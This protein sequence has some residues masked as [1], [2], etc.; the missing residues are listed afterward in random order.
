MNCQTVTANKQKIIISAKYL[1][2]TDIAQYCIY[3][4]MPKSTVTQHSWIAWGPQHQR[5]TMPVLIRIVVGLSGASRV[6]RVEKHYFH[7]REK[8]TGVVVRRRKSRRAWLT[9]TI[10]R[11]NVLIPPV[12]RRRAEISA[13]VRVVAQRSASIVRGHRYVRKLRISS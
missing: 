5:P 8:R 2:S 10:L 1:T 7:V 13:H 11:E 6:D 12:T 4:C 9:R 3:E